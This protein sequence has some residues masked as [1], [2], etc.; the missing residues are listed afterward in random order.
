MMSKL[1]I[2]VTLNEFLK[3]KERTKGFSRICLK[4]DGFY[5]PN[6]NWTDFTFSVLSEWNYHLLQIINKK[7]D[8]AILIFFSGSESLQIMKLKNEQCLL[9]V[10]TYNKINNSFTEEK[11]FTIDINDFI[12][13]LQV[14]NNLVNSFMLNNKYSTPDYLN[15]KKNASLLNEIV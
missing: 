1:K 5:F 11:A 9:K 7:V 2:I 6:E 3:E 15:F 10:G 14:V 8:T 12:H 13:E 4:I